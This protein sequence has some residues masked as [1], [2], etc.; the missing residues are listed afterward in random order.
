MITRDVK[1]RY[2]APSVADMLHV[3]PRLG[4]ALGFSRTTIGERPTVEF[5]DSVSEYPQPAAQTLSLLTQDEAASIDT[6]V[7]ILRPDRDDDQVQAEV[8]RIREDFD[9]GV[10]ADPL[11]P[12]R[13]SGEP[14][15]WATASPRGQPRPVAFVMTS[16]HLGH[17]FGRS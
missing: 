6:R 13:P 1:A 11:Q 9:T 17:G 3:M 15:T 2:W 14:P 4:R 12:S 16:R 5:G 7:R 10:P 8:R